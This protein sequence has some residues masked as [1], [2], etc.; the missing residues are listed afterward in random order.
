MNYFKT[1]TKLQ[2][3]IKLTY[4]NSSSHSVYLEVSINHRTEATLPSTVLI[5]V[6]MLSLC[7][8]P[9]MD[10]DL[11]IVPTLCDL[12]QSINMNISCVTDETGIGKPFTN[13]AFFMDMISVVNAFN[14]KEISDKRYLE[15]NNIPN[16]FL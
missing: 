16:Y 6:S 8:P 15:E 13:V 7:I 1:G 9:N 3:L 14:T 4:L 12:L 5:L 10:T 2:I 11:L